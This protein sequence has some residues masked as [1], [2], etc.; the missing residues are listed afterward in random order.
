MGPRSGFRSIPGEDQTV[1]RQ[2]VV[3]L[4]TSS[5]EGTPLSK[6]HGALVSYRLRSRGRDG[7]TGFEVASPCLEA[8]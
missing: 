4:D 8:G 3:C 5:M 6:H 7:N 1:A 2:L